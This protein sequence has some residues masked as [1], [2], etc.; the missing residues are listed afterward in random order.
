MSTFGQTILN[1]MRDAAMSGITRGVK[2]S[3]RSN[4][5][6]DLN[7][8]SINFEIDVQDKKNYTSQQ[9][10]LVNADGTQVPSTPKY[11]TDKEFDDAR[12]GSTIDVHHYGGSVYSSDFYINHKISD[13]EHKTDYNLLQFPNWGYDDYINERNIFVK[14]LSDG[15]DEP[16]WLYCRVFFNFN[17]FHGLLGGIMNDNNNSHIK[18]DVSNHY[19]GDD[20][21]GILGINTA[22]GYLSQCANLQTL[23]NVEDMPG[24]LKALKK[25]VNLLSQISTFS[26]WIFSGI[27]NLN[28]AS[29]VDLTKLTENKTFELKLNVDT[30][31]WRIS[32]LMSLY[33]YACYDDVNQKEILPDNL[34]KFDMSVVL[35]SVPIKYIH[36]PA[37]LIDNT[38]RGETVRTSYKQII[39]HDVNNMMSTK[40]YTFLG[41]ELNTANLGAYIPSNVT[42]DKPFQ[43]G[44][45][46]LQINY[47]RVYEYTFNEYEMLLI[48]SNCIA[49]FDPSNSGS[50]LSLLAEVE[51]LKA[52][53]LLLTAAEYYA[54]QKLN[55]VFKGKTSFILGNIYGQDHST[56]AA[57]ITTDLD[58][59][60]DLT[61]YYKT[62]TKMLFGAKPNLMSIAY[63]MF[64]KWMGSTSKYGTAP[65]ADGTGTILA[66][67]GEMGIGTPVWQAHMSRL[68]NGPDNPPI[69]DRERRRSVEANARNFNI[70]GYI[71]NAVTSKIQANN[72]IR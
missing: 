72:A 22:H 18:S 64:Y 11:S 66:G 48:G 53:N 54:V 67:N 68:F 8:D 15:L 24:R 7:T 27:S 32:T 51:R 65:S 42:N 37:L 40:V 36:T 39:S 20:N 52:G 14:H 26:P 49:S 38:G 47:D 9:S 13:N 61:E 44:N 45:S 62:K 1:T 43:L 3:E 21:D 6:L 41:C 56:Y 58:K 50:T 25:Y 29:N 16:N 55:D 2:M 34:R 4:N 30:V 35:F 28:N 46:S 19:F 60:S 17:T 31:D 63:N 57:H 33:K 10:P 23:Y 69:M 70:M 12:V 71:N 59:S 5:A